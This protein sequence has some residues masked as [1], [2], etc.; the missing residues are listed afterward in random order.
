M[1]SEVFLRC[2][3][4]TK[5]KKSRNIT[6]ITRETESNQRHIANQL[7]DRNRYHLTSQTATSQIPSLSK[8]TFSPSMQVLRS[9]TAP[10]HQCLKE[11]FPDNPALVSSAWESMNSTVT[12]CPA[13]RQWPLS[14]SSHQAITPWLPRHLNSLPLPVLS[15]WIHVNH[16]Y[17]HSHGMTICGPQ[18]E[19]MELG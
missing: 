12:L 7:R 15:F 1:K 11:V 19:K 18:R 13:R 9:M 8:N 6:D 2:K 10:S 14:Y 4:T 3:E 16:D 5:L 17:P